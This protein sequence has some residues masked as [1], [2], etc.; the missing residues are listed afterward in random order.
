MGERIGV[1][2]AFVGRPEGK[3][4]LRRPISKWENIRSWPVLVWLMMKRCGVLL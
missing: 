2:R 4:P 1:Y 3:R